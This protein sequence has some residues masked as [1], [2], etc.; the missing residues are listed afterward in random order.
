MTT[1][2]RGGGPG[3]VATHAVVIAAAL[4]NA[5]RGTSPLSLLSI[6]RV[7][8]GSSLSASSSSHAACSLPDGNV[9]P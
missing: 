8:M 5:A 2:A 7:V 1:I 6:S 4:A 3:G 9:A